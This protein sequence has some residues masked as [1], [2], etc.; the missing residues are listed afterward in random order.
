M[1]YKEL[2]A[3]IIDCAYKV[4]RE[5]CFG[6]LQAVY[7]NAL[8]IESKKPGLKVEMEKF[9]NVVAGFTT[10]SHNAPTSSRGWMASLVQ[11]PTMGN[12]CT[13]FRPTLTPF[14]RGGGIC[15]VSGWTLAK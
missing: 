5:L 14:P 9:S 7:Q 10:M 15:E 11:P 2:T 6:F 13:R 1:K 12:L 3:K 8:M 4:H